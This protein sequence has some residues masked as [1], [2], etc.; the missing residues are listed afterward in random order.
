VEHGYLTRRTSRLQPAFPD[1]EVDFQRVIT[2]KF[3]LL[4]Q[5]GSGSRIKRIAG[6]RGVF[7]TA[8][9]PGWTIS[10]ACRAQGANGGVGLD[11]LTIMRRSR[12]DEAHKFWQCE[13]FRQWDDLKHHSAAQDPHHGEFRLRGHEAPMC[14]RIRILFE[15]ARMAAIECGWRSSRLLPA[16]RTV[17]GQSDLSLGQTSGN[18]IQWWIDRLRGTLRVST[19]CD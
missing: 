13:F 15:L 1:G 9:A 11:R 14:G 17:V 6:V 18:R 19:C 10:L 4:R 12:G 16:R 8:S 5:A 2:Y 3:G 7:A